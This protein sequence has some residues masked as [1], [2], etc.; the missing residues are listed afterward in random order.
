MRAARSSAARAWLAVVAFCTIAGTPVSAQQP[1]LDPV[2]QRLLEPELRL[3]VAAYGRPRPELP[4]AAQPFGGA[5]AIDA[6]DAGRIRIGLL[7]ELP[8]PGAA[9]AL[10]ALAELRALG[11]DIGTVTGG[12]VT[13]RVPLDALELVVRLPL[14][15]VHAAR[16]L[17][18]VHDSSMIAIRADQVR[19]PDGGTWSGSTGAG[20]IVGVIDT[21]LD[22]MHP[23]FIDAAGNTRVLGLWDQT[24]G[25]RPPPGFSYGMYCDGAAVQI[26]AATGDR[27]QCPS[28]DINGHGTHVA[29]TAA[30][31]GSAGTEPF[32]YAGVAPLAD[33]LIVK[34]GDGVFAEDRIIDGLVWLRREAQAQG[35][36]AVVNL[37]LG[38]QYGAHD[39]TTLIERVIDELSGPGF[40][41]VIAAGNDGAN[42]NL[43]PAPPTAPR[44]IHARVM[45]VP[46]QAHTVQFEVTQYTPNAN[47]C[48]GNF[49]ELS[50]WYDTA[51]R[52]EITVVRPNGT[53]VTAASGTWSGSSDA[54][55]RIEI[56]NA[57]PLQAFPQTAEGYIQI[58]GCNGSGAPAP[59]SW[60][61]RFRPVPVAGGTSQPVDLYL[62]TVVLGPGGSA[63][64][65]SGFD[66]RYIVSAPATARRGIAVGAFVTR[67]CWPSATGGT[68]CYT[69]RTE[70]GD[71]ASFSSAGPSRDG[72]IKPDI[73][74]PGM[75]IASSLSQSRSGGGRTVVGGMH[76]VLEGTSMA[77]PH[78]AGAV[79]LLL[80]HRPALSPEDV[81]DIL[82]RTART[83]LF[84]SRTYGTAPGAQPSDWW[85]HGKL[86]VAAAV[87]ELFA[88]GTVSAVR[89]TP[90][91]DTV[92]VGGIAQFRAAATNEAGEV[93]F[94]NVLWSSLDAAI[95]SVD[96]QGRV[97][98]VQPGQARI[99]ARTDG[100]AD[101]AL[102]VVVP[103]AVLAVAGRSIVPAA[104]VLGERDTWL[105]LLAVSLEAQ[106]PE[107]IQV[108][109]LG[110]ELTGLD[111]GARLVL[112]A[113]PAG[114]GQLE[115]AAHVVAEREALLGGEPR[116]ITLNTDTL[117]VERNAT[118]HFILAL[119]L[120]GRAPMGTAFSARLLPE[121]VT[122]VNLN[123]GAR[124]RVVLADAIVSAPAPT[125]VLREGELFA[126]SENPVRSGSVVLN[127]AE[128]P[129]T[130][131][132]YTVT[133]SRVADLT[134][135]GDGLWL[136]W[137]LTNDAGARVVSGVYLLV[138]RIGSVTVREKLMILAPLGRQ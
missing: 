87:A 70:T 65:S 89:I 27:T 64:G 52:V 45:P 50:A 32:R 10:A 103:P 130:A 61:V 25:A 120:S 129:T 37:S 69:S 18:H 104:P 91:R 19:R 95:A 125:T 124:D 128:P 41:V 28:R 66:N 97:R 33:L 3:E 84:T 26:V 74:A 13:A 29:G 133:G 48:T 109:A 72:R 116:V 9:A 7:L 14:E 2:V 49:I 23:D 118:R 4:P 63:S 24:T 106:G 59:G 71:I 127:F 113:D 121:A 99:V 22:V 43:T 15:R 34:A 51:D 78:V 39:G 11:A 110:F 100:V 58:N 126:L 82:A 67:N 75:G 17:R 86:D 88:G 8:A 135:R 138:L 93:T 76:W 5:Y 12:I 79:A 36:P 102:V 1:V 57:T 134:R 46:G 16:T 55:G 81:R 123:S 96:A 62:H 56:H 94:A 92:P 122:T 101:T 6:D 68:V 107:S 40:I 60:Q 90:P 112:L 132:V 114:T 54:Q 119:V 83:D 117:I 77:A 35:R 85:G 20:A 30:G 98:G 31:D 47:L 38:H 115:D 108:R 80:Q 131:A 42:A 105:P 44:L 53:A 137:D 73:T 21:G 136:H 111:P